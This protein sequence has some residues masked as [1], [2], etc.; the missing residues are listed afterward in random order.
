M[1]VRV[2]RE[3]QLQEPVGTRYVVSVEERGRCGTVRTFERSDAVEAE[4]LARA[5]AIRLATSMRCRI[6]AS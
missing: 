5:C 6:V 4:H 3:E 2:V 1:V